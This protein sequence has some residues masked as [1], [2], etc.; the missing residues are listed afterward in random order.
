MVDEELMDLKRKGEEGDNDESQEEEQ[1]EEGRKRR[2]AQLDSG[3]RGSQLSCIRS[4]RL[5]SLSMGIMTP[6]TQY[7]GTRSGAVDLPLL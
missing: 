6:G 4:K 1:N 5:S 3:K 7:G 2:G